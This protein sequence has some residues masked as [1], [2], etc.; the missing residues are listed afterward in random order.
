[1]QSIDVPNGREEGTGERTSP[2]TDRKFELAYLKPPAAGAGAA[3][4]AP[5]KEKPPAAG[6]G[7]GVPKR[8]MSN[9]ICKRV[10]SVAGRGGRQMMAGI[11]CHRRTQGFCHP[12]AVV[13]KGF[14][15]FSVCTHAG[16]DD[17]ESTEP[18]L[19]GVSI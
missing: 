14:S 19:N 6:A 8:L 12:W 2:T 10:A 3:A 7:A 11:F 5:P 17:N 16:F 18:S 4:G 9:K 1:M 15:R 13:T